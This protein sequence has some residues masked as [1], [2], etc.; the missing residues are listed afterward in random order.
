MK[1]IFI[2]GLEHSG[3]TLLNHLLCQHAD[4]V[5]LG[6]VASF[7]NP[8]HMKT[9]MQRWG[10]YSDVRL[11]SCGRPWE[12][13]QIWKDLHG[14]NGMVSEEPL[15]EKYRKLLQHF[16]LRY[17]DLK[18][19]V[20]SSKSF[21]V[22]SLIVENAKGLGLQLE[23]LL[24][25]V[26]VKDVRSFTASI[27]AKEKREHSLLFALRTFNWWAGGN[28]RFLDYLS[29]RVSHSIVLYEH[30][31]LHPEEVVS[32]IYSR[33]GL[34]PGRRVDLNHSNSHIAMGNKEFIMRNRNTIRYDDRWRKNRRI[35]AVYRFHVGARRLNEALH[36]SMA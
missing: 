17:P 32:Q 11:C 2:A 29:G 34:E 20:D 26:A 23:D 24:V 36:A 15:R 13:C 4:A 30:L 18:L 25:V 7:F 14:L 28:R 1:Y 5:G 12:S 22:M 6:E 35:N 8:E 19:I 3:S 9:Y 27:V 16:A 31:C 10:A 21:P 33:V